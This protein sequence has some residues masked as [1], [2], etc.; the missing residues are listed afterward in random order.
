MH[1][2]AAKDLSGG[3]L[4]RLALANATVSYPPIY[5]LTKSH[6][7]LTPVLKRDIWNY[8]HELVEESGSSVVLT[9]HDADEIGELANDIVIVKDGK[10]MTS[11]SPLGLR[12]ELGDYSIILTITSNAQLEAWGAVGMHLSKSVWR[13]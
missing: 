4:R 12:S 11:N 9:T 10:V 1:K 6:L 7:A 13:A 3:M 8:I 2:R 5:L